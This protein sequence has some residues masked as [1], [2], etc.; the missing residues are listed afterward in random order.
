MTSIWRHD[1]SRCQ[2]SEFR[3][4]GRRVGD[5]E[6]L[7][8]PHLLGLQLHIP[9]LGRFLLF[10][11]QNGKAVVRRSLNVGSGKRG[12]SNNAGRRNSET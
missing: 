11:N 9:G 2:A 1:L 5:V 4:H 12:L 6:V 7:N 8:R 10:N 3:F